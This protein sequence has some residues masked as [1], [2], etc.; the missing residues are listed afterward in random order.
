VAFSADDFRRHYSSLSDVA[1]LELN[2]DEL[3]PI[4][5][6]CY[7][8]EI[9]KRGITSDEAGDEAF[10]EGPSPGEQSTAEDE[11]VC[12]AEY[13][14]VDEAEL[15]KGLLEGA[16]IRA[17]ID[18]DSTLVRLMAPPDLA[19]AALQLLA[20]PLSDEELAAQAEAAGR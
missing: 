1:L 7:E 12:I 13:D 20:A 3:N 18:R 19:E 10:S 6:A 15:A 5:R 11:M 16:E 4:A 14:Y 2:P 17:V 8:D 9:A